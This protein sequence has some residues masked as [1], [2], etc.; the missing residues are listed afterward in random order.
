MKCHPEVVGRYS[1]RQLFQQL[2]AAQAEEQDFIQRAIAAGASIMVHDSL[3]FDDEEKAKAF[4]TSETR[5]WYDQQ[6]RLSRLLE[7]SEHE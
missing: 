2:S 4:L 3:A 7:R 1:S 6:L 5:R